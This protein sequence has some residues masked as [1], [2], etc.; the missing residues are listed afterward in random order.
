VSLPVGPGTRNSTSWLGAGAIL[1]IAAHASTS[2]QESVSLEKVVVTG[3]HIPQID[4]ETALPVQIITREE[5]ERSGVTTAA[6]LLERVPANVNGFSDALSIGQAGRPGLASANLRGLGDGS[7]LVL[8]NGRRLANYAFAGSTVDLNSLPL[9]AVE[10]VEVLKDGA[11]AIYGSDALAGV[12]NFILRK[13][14]AGAE[15]TAYGAVTQQGGGDSLLATASFGVT[16]SY[17]S[18]QALKAADRDFARTGYR[19]DLGV[20]GRS[21]LTFPANVVAGRRL[22]NPTF[23]QGCAPPSTLPQPPAACAY[24]ATTEI[25]LLPA[26]ERV[27]VLARGT[28]RWSADTD[29]FA[30]ALFSRNQRLSRERAVLPDSV[31]CCQWRGGRSL[32][33]VSRRGTRSARQRHR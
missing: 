9:A 25:D 22:L 17:Q 3:S 18:D 31:G 13:N 5:I 27:S 28:W 24:D 4:G 8:L 29:V 21:A 30:E 11:S 2:A 14:Y 15:V 32:A 19:P 12:V 1:A 20:D 6:Q 7:T 23:A 16:A 26:I 10:R 33:A